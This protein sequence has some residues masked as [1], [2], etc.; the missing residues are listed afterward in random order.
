[1]K[2]SKV[3]KEEEMFLLESGECT[4]RMNAKDNNQF[5]RA[6]LALIEEAVNIEWNSKLSIIDF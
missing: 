5:L 3:K 2:T 1:M 4:T 6:M